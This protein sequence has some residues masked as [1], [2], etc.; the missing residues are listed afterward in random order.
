MSNIQGTYVV[1]RVVYQV[2]YEVIYRLVYRVLCKVRSIQSGIYGGVQ[3]VILCTVFTYYVYEVVA[4]RFLRLV[5]HNAL[6]TWRT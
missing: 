6:I 4:E 2:L 5:V 3:S 1:Y